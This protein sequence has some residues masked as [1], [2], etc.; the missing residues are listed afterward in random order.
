MRSAIDLEA[1]RE[2]LRLRRLPPVGVIGLG[3]LIRA[4]QRELPFENLDV[5]A[6][7]RLSL[8]L[9][10]LERKLIAGGRG[11]FCYELNVLFAGF[12]RQ[13][14][15]RVEYLQ[16]RVMGRKLSPRFAHLC[17]GVTLDQRYLVDVG[18]GEFAEGPLPLVAGARINSGGLLHRLVRRGREL[19]VEQRVRGGKWE[20]L[21][22]V[23][24]RAH[25]LSAFR[26][27]F[28]FQS[29]SP[30]SFFA[31]GPGCVRRT[32]AGWVTIHNAELTRTRGGVRRK[33]PLAPAAVHGRLAR[34]LRLPAE[35]VGALLRAERH[36]PA[37]G[38][39]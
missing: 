26:E 15:Y 36:G 31:R 39:R 13:Q 27:L 3:R 20:V 10:P 16:A 23:E 21:Y 6:G 14:G 38:A 22:R 33:E 24:P 35:E 30:E 32:R 29:R 37:A 19:E 17:L 18:Y 5:L 12:L 25:P 4:H 8:G 28:E 34:L 11:G 7:R 1:Y 2:R 9:G